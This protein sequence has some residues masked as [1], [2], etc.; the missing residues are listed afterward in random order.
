MVTNTDPLDSVNPQLT[1]INTFQV[2]VNGIHN[3]PSLSQ[4]SGVTIDAI[5]T[6]IVT[7]TATDN[8]I[9]FTGLTYH[10]VNPPSGALIDGN[11]IITWSPTTNQTGASTITTVVTDGAGTPLS[12]TNSFNITVNAVTPP[13]IPVH[14]S[15]QRCGDDYMV[16]DAGPRLPLAVQEYEQYELDRSA[17]GHNDHQWNHGQ[18][19]E[20]MRAV[21]DAGIPDLG[22]TH[23]CQT[24]ADVNFVCGPGKPRA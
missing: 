24:V 4:K 6:L 23:Y 15:H 19:D 7:N 2:V 17:G 5:T 11:G 22:S 14:R 1:A 3:G 9:P 20:F 13:V 16:G 12:A 8:D 18:H 21:V 10:L